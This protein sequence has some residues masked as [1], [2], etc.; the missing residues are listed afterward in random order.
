[1]CIIDENEIFNKY[2]RQGDLKNGET[3]RYGEILRSVWK[4]Q[5]GTHCSK[6]MSTSTEIS[7]FYP[8]WRRLWFP[9]TL[10][11]RAAPDIA[12]RLWKL[13]ASKSACAGRLYIKFTWK[14][15]SIFAKHQ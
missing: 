3:L 8:C 1:M 10:Q 11:R 12:Q 13:W 14:H 4:K 15:Q 6:L 5:S 7:V 9:Q 2:L